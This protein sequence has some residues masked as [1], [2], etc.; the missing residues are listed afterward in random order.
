MLL[1]ELVYF[2][3]EKTRAIYVSRKR[4]SKFSSEKLETPRR[5]STTLLLTCLL[6][7]L[8]TSRLGPVAFRVGSSVHSS[9]L[10]QYCCLIQEDS[11]LSTILQLLRAATRPPVL[12]TR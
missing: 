6:I 1:A 4:V 5:R 3:W 2:F 10:I 8:V 7:Y 12:L 9:I 11:L